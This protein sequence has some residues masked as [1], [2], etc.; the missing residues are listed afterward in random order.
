[1][2]CNIPLW[3]KQQQTYEELTDLKIFRLKKSLTNN[4]HC[5]NTSYNATILVLPNLGEKFLFCSKCAWTICPS[6]NKLGVFC[7]CFWC[8]VSHC[9]FS[10]CW[11]HYL[12][13]FQS[14]VLQT[15][16]C[17]LVIAASSNIMKLQLFWSHLGRNFHFHQGCTTLV[18]FVVLHKTSR[19]E[20][21][22]LRCYIVI[23]DEICTSFLVWKNNFIFS[24]HEWRTLALSIIFSPKL[25]AEILVRN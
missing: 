11:G 7:V 24:K 17:H 18:S 9:W 5:F 2:W 8:C 25:H 4:I 10:L 16:T 21:N 3:K 23:I 6:W 13:S 15:C 20:L 22:G 19:E 1:L 14:F 12:V